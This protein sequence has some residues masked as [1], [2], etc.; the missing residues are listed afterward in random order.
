MD[1]LSK[2]TQGLLASQ[3]RAT[4]LAGRIVRDSAADASTTNRILGA[5]EGTGTPPAPAQAAGEQAG[6]QQPQAGAA[7]RPPQVS[8]ADAA[9]FSDLIQTVVDFRAEQNVFRA[10]AAAFSRIAETENALGG[11]LDDES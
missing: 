9:G 3:Q 7:P 4:D 10:N 6:Q 1:A 11:L 8:G 2:A 5:A